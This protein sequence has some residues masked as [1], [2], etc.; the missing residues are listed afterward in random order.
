MNRRS[1]VRARASA[2]LAAGLLALSARI[3][4]AERADEEAADQPVAGDATLQLSPASD[5]ESQAEIQGALAEYR[6]AV[7]A[8]FSRDELRRLRLALIARI[9]RALSYSTTPLPDRSLRSEVVFF[10]LR[11]LGPRTSAT[12]I[13]PAVRELQIR[14]E[15]GCVPIVESQVWAALEHCDYDLGKLDAQFTKYYGPLP[16]PPVLLADLDGDGGNELVIDLQSVLDGGAFLVSQRTRDGY[17]SLQHHPEGLPDQMRY[18]FNEVTKE[19]VLTSRR[20]HRFTGRKKLEGK[21][22]SVFED[23]EMEARFTF[24]GVEVR[25]TKLPTRVN[26]VTSVKPIPVNRGAGRRGATSVPTEEA[27]AG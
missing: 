9:D 21:W 12:E 16:M 26:V 22:V 17:V 13:F 3:W 10:Y 5:R 19:I 1:A 24:D 25:Q 6:D 15:I 20:F 18:S 8:G 7:D 2:M 23:Y 11:W 4:S 14:S 27:E